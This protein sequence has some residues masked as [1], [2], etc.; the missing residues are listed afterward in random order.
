[1]SVRELPAHPDLDQLRRQAKELARSSGDRLGSA[2]RTLA[3]EYGFASWPRLVR[4]VRRVRLLDSG[5]AVGLAALLSKHPELATEGLRVNGT[6]YGMSPLHYIGIGR[7]HNW[8]RHESS[9]ALT[10]VLLAAG[11]DARP[12]QAPLVTAASHGELGMLRALLAAGADLEVTGDA[13]PGSRTPLAHAVHYGIAP[14]VDLLVEAGAIV[15]DLT[16]S[17]GVGDLDRVDAFL[18]EPTADRLLALRA[19]AV[20]E[21][22][23]VLDRLLRTGIDVDEEFTTLTEPNGA[24]VLHCAAWEGKPASVE[25][26]LANGADPDHR[27][28]GRHHDVERGTPLDWCRLRAGVVHSG[29][30]AAVEELL[31]P[32]T[33]S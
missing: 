9:E 21:R 15:H 20:C 1:M 4:E 17:A 27:I 5:D 2:Q 28:P 7:L 14:A 18:R 31:A 23:H 10:K 32:V 26:L 19:A 8:W 29:D 11:A 12:N 24:T 16:E 3:R 25:L 6:A 22:V 30:H 33:T 13:A